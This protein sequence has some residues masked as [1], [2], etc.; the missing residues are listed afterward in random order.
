[1]AE[2]EKSDFSP[3]LALKLA[4]GGVLMVAGAGLLVLWLRP[5]AI[6]DRDLEAAL[7]PMESPALQVNPRADMKRFHD[8]EMG[9]LAGYG[10]IDREKGIAQIP[11]EA[12]MDRVARDGIPGWPKEARQ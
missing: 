8:E 1:M 7:I 4:A 12:A 5:D 11:I 2:F 3:S 9:D 6:H 10:W